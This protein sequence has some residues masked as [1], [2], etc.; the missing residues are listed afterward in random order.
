MDT[1]RLYIANLNPLPLYA[2][3]QIPSDGY[4]VK[5]GQGDMT[6]LQMYCLDSAFEIKIYLRDVS[7]RYITE[8]AVNTSTVSG[9]GGS[10]TRFYTS[11]IK[12]SQVAEGGYYIE[13]SI[14]NNVGETCSYYSPCIEVRAKH[15]NTF[16]IEYF[17]SENVHDVLFDNGTSFALRVEGGFL[18]KSYVPKVQET[19]YQNQKVEFRLLS[20]TPYNAN[21]LTAG[22]E[23]GIPD[24]IF[25]KVHRSLSCD[26]LIIENVAMTKPEGAE[27]TATE[28]DGY[29]FRTWKIELVQANDNIS[30]PVLCIEQAIYSCDFEWLDTGAVCRLEPDNVLETIEFS[31][32]T[33]Q[34]TWQKQD[35]AG[36]Y[37]QLQYPGSMAYGNGIFIGTFG[38][39]NTSWEIVK[40][41]S[42]GNWEGMSFGVIGI[43]YQVAF[44]NGIFVVAID[45]QGKV[46]YSADGLT[47]TAVT[48]NAS[49]FGK[50]V[51]FGNGI[52]VAVFDTNFYTSP[53]GIN[54]TNTGGGATNVKTYFAGGIFFNIGVQ[55]AYKYSTDG[56]NWT[57]GRMWETTAHC[58]GVA[59]GNGMYV[60][61][62]GISGIYYSYDGANWTKVAISGYFFSIAF[63][64]GIFVAGSEYGN[65]GMSTDGISWTVVGSGTEVVSSIGAFGGGKFAFMSTEAVLYSVITGLAFAKTANYK[66]Y[67]N[68]ELDAEIT[69]SL[70]S[71]V[72]PVL[73]EAVYKQL[74]VGEVEERAEAAVM[75]FDVETEPEYLSEPVME[76]NTCV[77]DNS[78]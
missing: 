64:N 58:S 4:A 33:C 70:L 3:E 66:R 76:D 20:S 56:V 11:L 9:D 28:V 35:I 38:R 52:F 16:L 31:D 59:Y 48:V 32:Y 47:W 5:Y 30:R 29:G 78:E 46:V 57:D 12:F 69:K 72:E 15:E 65:L 61:V 1:G 44:G 49:A 74:T 21:I 68:E 19:V 36:Q 14:K 18:P 60:A 8:Y 42:E 73:S 67:I 55:G 40:S 7:D 23:R 45:G 51:A 63:G 53:D 22:L 54:W 62:G 50:G 34:M 43:P 17:N 10:I 13:V 6:C 71:D 25:D 77:E 27:W 39:Y 2:R 75:L 24:W 41:D 37:E 26:G